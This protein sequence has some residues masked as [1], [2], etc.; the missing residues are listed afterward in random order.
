MGS[1]LR[2]LEVPTQVLNVE[3]PL[4]E[5]VSTADMAGEVF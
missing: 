5:S 2:R 1:S 3:G 4:W